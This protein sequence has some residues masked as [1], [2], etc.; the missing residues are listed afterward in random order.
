VINKSV[1]QTIIICVLLL[2]IDR[3]F[4]QKETR[5]YGSL[6]PLILAQSITTKMVSKVHFEKNIC[7]FISSYFNI[8]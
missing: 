2:F 7:I 3:D 5:D 6:S 8:F 1:Q 4:F